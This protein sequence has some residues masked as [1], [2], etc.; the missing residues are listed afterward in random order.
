MAN[1][2]RR[3]VTGHDNEGKSVFISDSQPPRCI[4]FENLPGLEFVELWATDGIPTIPVD[5]DPTLRMST[6]VPEPAST[7]FRIVKFP[8]ELEISALI[9]KGFSP[10]DFRKEYIE[11]VP[12]LAETDEIENPGMHTTDTIDYG[13]VLS[14]EIDMELDEG[15]EVHFR[16]GDC[17]VQNGTRHRW[18]NRS[19]EPCIIAFIMV[20]AKRI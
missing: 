19:E 20:G 3:V 9:Q 11:K 4:S 17:L 15:R 2:V 16:A 5:N 12:G 8:P 6:F 1:T 18:Q 13:I 7:R 14:G 10:A